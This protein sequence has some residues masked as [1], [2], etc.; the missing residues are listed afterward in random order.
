MPVLVRDD[1]KVAE[2]CTSPS[3]RDPESEAL[4]LLR[5]VCRIFT[6]EIL[7]VCE[8]FCCQDMSTVLSRSN[9]ESLSILFEANKS[10]VEWQNHST[11]TAQ[12]RSIKHNKK[13]YKNDKSMNSNEGPY[14]LFFF[15]FFMPDYQ[16]ELILTQD[17]IRST[18]FIAI[19]PPVLLWEEFSALRPT[20]QRRIL[21]RSP[22]DSGRLLATRPPERYVRGQWA[23]AEGATNPLGSVRI[24]SLS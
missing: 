7:A 11:E 17:M 3:R 10:G 15:F 12:N 20:P 9:R 21:R 24:S 16:I 8:N 6:V 5:K 22:M 2:K 23:D 14:Y 1:S 13:E 4:I 19:K 18:R